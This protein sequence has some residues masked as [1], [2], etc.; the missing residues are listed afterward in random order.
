MLE[1]RHI[2]G[3]TWIHSCYLQLKTRKNKKK[4]T[5]KN[6]KKLKNNTLQK[7]LK[8]KTKPLGIILQCKFKFNKKIK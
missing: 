7:K 1:Y 6:K 8:R 4:K 3:Y 2:K 5:Y